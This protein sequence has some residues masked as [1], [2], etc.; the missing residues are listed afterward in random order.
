MWQKNGDEMEKNDYGFGLSPSHY[1]S[2][3]LIHDDDGVCHYVHAY[4]FF[5]QWKKNCM[6]PYHDDDAK[7]PD[8]SVLPKMIVKAI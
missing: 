6:L 5:H 3:H 7:S 2:L 4:Q 1:Y 8:G